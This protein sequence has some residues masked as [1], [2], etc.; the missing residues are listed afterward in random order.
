MVFIKRGLL[1]ELET[2]LP[3]KEISLIV[4]PR[5]V[6]KTTMMLMLKETLE[7]RGQ[8]GEKTVFLNLDSELDRPFFSSQSSFIRKLKLELGKERGYV[9]IDEIQRKENAGLFLKGV[10]DT[11]LPYKLIAS[12]SGSLELKEKIHESLVG[13]KRIFELNPVSFEEFVNFKTNYR[14][15]G[16]HR[17]FFDIEK[18]KSQDLLEEYLNFGGYPRVILE[19]K[20]E[21]KRRIIDDIFRSYLEKDITFLLRVEKTE[22]FSS[23][24]RILASQL[25]RLINYSALC[26][27][28]GIAIQTLKNYLWYGEKTFVIQ[29]LP[30]YYRNVRKE[31]VKSPVIYFY[32]NGL[33]NYPLGLFGNLY[34]P[35]A[36]GH[37]FENFIFNILR[38]KLRFSGAKL[39]FWR[40]KDGA[41]VDFVV[42]FAKKIIPMEVKYKRL[43]KIEISRSLRSFMEKYKPPHAIIVNLS[44]SE[45]INIGRT[46][47]TFLPYYKLFDTSTITNQPF[48]K[49]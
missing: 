28:L 12:G 18:E 15:E 32:D 38:E 36:F 6:G 27:T 35:E 42:D 24:I 29:R 20:L 46:N 25:G 9:F 34:N 5:Q 23:L 17:D 30:P 10:Y 33:R 11:N 13:R 37:L 41:E 21:E 47:V 14:Y 1:E 8:R 43:P 31:I 45:T 7:Q 19:E 49:L 4:G 22:A 48:S 39:Y 40:T 16:K 3:Q 2:H 26:T 44:L